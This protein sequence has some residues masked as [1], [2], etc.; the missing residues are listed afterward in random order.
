MT[1]N[2]ETLPKRRRTKIQKELLKT[3]NLLNADN[4]KLWNG[5]IW[6]DN[7]LVLDENEI[8]YTLEGND[9]TNTSNDS[10]LFYKS[11]KKKRSYTLILTKNLKV[12]NGQ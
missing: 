3:K 8:I 6:N 1:K 11:V 2:K 4:G 7:I 5:N 10:L 9:L 12:N